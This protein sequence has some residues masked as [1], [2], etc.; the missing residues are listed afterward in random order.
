MKTLAAVFILLAVSVS[1]DDFRLERTEQRS[2]T[3]RSNGIEYKLYVS[4]PHSY[5]TEG[6][7]FPVVYL[8]DADY[9]FLIARNITDHLAERN[10][11]PELILVGIAYGGPPQYRLNRTRDYTPSFVP[12]G[13][14]GPEMQ[15]VSGGEPKFREFLEQELI[16]FVDATYATVA[17]DRCLVGHSYGGLFGTTNLLASPALFNRYIIVSASLWYD[18]KLMLRREREHARSHKELAVRV[19]MAAGNQEDTRMAGDLR[20][21]A[22]ALRSHRYRGLALKSEILT[23]ENHN[24]IFP[25]ALSNG[26]R[27]VFD[28]R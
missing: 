23:K 22:T 1:A 8:L 3:S 21:L 26:L 15:K 20:Q 25:R 10:D 4:L 9:S 2:L 16:P 7:R 27:F 6:K 5:G 14:Y 11:L 19:Y 12:T 18:G 28:V 24:T 17:G 13:G